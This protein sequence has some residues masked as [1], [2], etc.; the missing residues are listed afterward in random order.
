MDVRSDVPCPN[1]PFIPDPKPEDVPLAI[2]FVE[3]EEPA[4]PIAPVVA[5]EVRTVDDDPPTAIPAL[6]KDCH[7]VRVASPPGY[8]DD[9][10]WDGGPPW[11]EILEEF[12]EAGHIPPLAIA[13]IDPTI[14]VARAPTTRTGLYQHL[15]Y[16]AYPRTT[17]STRP[18]RHLLRYHDAFSHLQSTGSYNYLMSLAIGTGEFDAATDL[19]GEMFERGF[20]NMETRA[21]RVRLMVRRGFWE[22]AWEEESAS[23][24]LPLPVWLEFLGTVHHSI[25]PMLE[26]EAVEERNRFLAHLRSMRE[27]MATEATETAAAAT[28][29]S[30][31]DSSESA[32]GQTSAD[33][34]RA[35]LEDSSQPSFEDLNA[36]YGD[37]ASAPNLIRLEEGSFVD[38]ALGGTVIP[39]SEDPVASESPDNR[40]WRRRSQWD[41]VDDET[42]H[43]PSQRLGQPAPVDITAEQGRYD[44]L[45]RHFPALTPEQSAKMPPRV[46]LML[47]R[48]FIRTNNPQKAFSATESY[49]KNLPPKLS[50][51][52]RH[53]CMNIVHA[54]LIPNKPHLSGHYLARRTLVKLLRLHSDLKPDATTLLYLINSLRTV[55]QCGTAAMGLMQ[56]FRRRFGPGVVDER[57]RW[58]L[59][60]LALKERN[61]RVAERVFTEHDAEQARQTEL[62]L[63]RETHGHR[64]LGKKAR[65]PSFRELLPARELE[66]YWTPLRNRL[67]QLKSRKKVQTS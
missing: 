22:R 29:P 31:L 46:T 61:L 33:L 55:P 41:E 25:P 28:P 40:L 36:S 53:A 12:R 23:G 37:W 18:L 3:V 56:E 13:C 35:N 57:V 30:S 54:Q 58:R 44:T 26:P 24:E 5:E 10:P 47:V 16:L 65:R 38:S 27:A 62:D 9:P 20:G 32:S 67:Y 39:G 34:P 17:G 63:L 60:W 64:A 2:A 19:L 51:V 49:F 1:P 66:Q 21:L 4:T 59:A 45:M 7:D 50:P 6:V 48:W 52:S 15:I 42:W 43:R 8:E 11:D 14:R